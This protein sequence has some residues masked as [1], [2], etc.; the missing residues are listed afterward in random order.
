MGTP[1][2]LPSPAPDGKGPRNQWPSN[3]RCLPCMHLIT[4][5]LT[6]ELVP[7]ISLRANPRSFASA[8][9]RSKLSLSDSLASARDALAAS[10]L[11]FC[12]NTTVVVAALTASAVATTARIGRMAFLLLG[13]CPL[14]PQGSG[15]ES[16]IAPAD[17]ERIETS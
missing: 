17:S 4:K 6:G 11:F 16:S 15:F 7:P 13:H 5:F 14:R 9:H 3:Q 8:T 12:A 2:V 1:P 10:V